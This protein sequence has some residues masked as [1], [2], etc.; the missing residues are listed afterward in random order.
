MVKHKWNVV[1]NIYF[2]FSKNWVLTFRVNYLPRRQFI[3]HVKIFESVTLWALELIHMKCHLIQ[4]NQIEHHHKNKEPVKAP[5]K[6]VFSYF[7]MK[8]YNVVTHQKGFYET[9]FHLPAR[10]A[11]ISYKIRRG[12]KVLKD[13]RPP[14][15]C[16]FR[17]ASPVSKKILLFRLLSQDFTAPELFT[18]TPAYWYTASA[19]RLFAKILTTECQSHWESNGFWSDVFQPISD[20]VTKR[21]SHVLKTKVDVSRFVAITW[22]SLKPILNCLRLNNATQEKAKNY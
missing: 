20:R 3:W 16:F 14:D 19:S 6:T 9:V 13:L 22:V 18:I 12:R 7:S 17:V 2:Y 4:H 8:I 10:P 15:A 5:D 11:R 21:A 1:W